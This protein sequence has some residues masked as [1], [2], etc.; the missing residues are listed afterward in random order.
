MVVNDEY[1]SFCP[2]C[3]S[4]ILN[5]KSVINNFTITRC[6][7]CKLM[8]VKEKVSQKELDFYYKQPCWN[9]AYLN[10]KN[11]ENLKYYYQNLRDIIITHI[12]SGTILDIGCN[13]GYFLDVMD[14]FERYGIERSESA[15]KVA[16]DRYGD[17]IF[18]GKFED[19][20]K[21]DFLFD[22]IT[23]QDVLDHVTDPV[24][25]LKKCNGFLRPGGILVVKVHDMGSLYAKVMGKNYYAFI[26]PGH[27]FYFNKE[28]ISKLLDKAG[29]DIVISKYMGHLLLFST[30][31]FRLSRGN[32]K[33]IFF[34]LYKIVDGR[35]L[36]NV[37][38][39][40]NLRDV[41]T[42]VAVKR[43]VN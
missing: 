18:I 39:Y 29:F 4:S 11:T 2:V 14:G 32:E 28:S 38:I 5:N 30:I 8:F 20:K 34:H 1:H 17:N 33:S 21:P 3:H 40:K 42:I 37:K 12:G 43:N 41:V 36:G 9:W 22:C 23:M 6:R 16:K 35:K 31:L 15:G 7:S 25:V 13:A 24:T 26:P 19:Y 10:S 27:L